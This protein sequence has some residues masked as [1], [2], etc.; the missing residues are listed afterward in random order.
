VTDAPG[1]ADTVDAGDPRVG[2]PGSTGR[3]GD[4]LA[5]A[6]APPHDPQVDFLFD[7]SLGAS[8]PS[9]P[10]PPDAVEPIPDYVFDQS[11][12]EDWDLSPEPPGPES[13][14][15]DREATDPDRD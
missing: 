6:R 1:A 12:P 5:P 9:D 3:E 7:Q 11:T 15:E 4:L 8:L 2:Q 10:F 13:D 14:T